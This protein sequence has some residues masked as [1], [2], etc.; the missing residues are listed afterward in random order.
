MAKVVRFHELGGPEVL[1]LEEI[2][3]EDPAPG[4]LRLKVGVIGLNRLEVVYRSG[5]FGTPNKYPAALGSECAGTVEAIGKGV[6]GFKIGDRVSFFH[7]CEATRQCSPVD[8]NRAL[9]AHL[10]QRVEFVLRQRH[11]R[12]RDIL[13]KVGDSGGSRDRHNDW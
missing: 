7:S 5:G 11:R 9:A 13:D 2:T 4:E 6:T 3:F 10:I 12:R 1:R 8:L